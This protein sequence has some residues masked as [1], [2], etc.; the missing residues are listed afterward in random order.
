MTID[1]DPVETPPN[2]AENERASV[3]EK[4]EADLAEAR[5]QIAEWNRG[6][7]QS[8]EVYEAELAEARAQI[9]ALAARHEKALVEG[10]ARLAERDEARA[11]IAALKEQLAKR[12]DGDAVL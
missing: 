3:F 2:A 1:T 12:D 11:Q 7:R 4:L 8:P 5:A 9:A 6:Q 10:A